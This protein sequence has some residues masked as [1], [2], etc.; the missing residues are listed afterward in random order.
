MKTANHIS[1]FLVAF[2][3]FSSIGGAQEARTAT[4]ATSPKSISYEQLKGILGV[5]KAKVLLLDVRTKEEF[6][7]GH[8]PGSMLMPYDTIQADFKEADKSRPIV[9]YCRSGNRSSVAARTLVRMGYTDV[10]DFGA[11]TLWKGMLKN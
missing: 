6:D 11:V 2:F 3:A 5:T 1:I 10:S 9:V 4:A 8:I 7:Q